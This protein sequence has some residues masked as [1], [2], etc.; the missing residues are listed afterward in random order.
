MSDQDFKE[1]FYAS[2]KTIDLVRN[3]LWW[4]LAGLVGATI[5]VTV[6]VVRVND[7]VKSLE[8]T[9]DELQKSVDTIVLWKTETQANR[10]DI[11]QW[12][13]AQTGINDRFTTNEKRIQRNIDM[14]ET[15]RSTLDKKLEITPK[16]VLKK[17]ESVEAM[18]KRN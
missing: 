13:E 8:K 15:V 5:T 4:A 6:W 10:F 18:I 3:L 16:D 11:H 12:N 2:L 7:S 17:L 9:I 14:L 1:H